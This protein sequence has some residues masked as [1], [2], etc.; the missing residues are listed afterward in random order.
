MVATLYRP[1]HEPTNVS[2]NG[3]HLPDSQT[4][5]VPHSNT[6]ADLLGCDSRLVDILD[7]GP[8][9]VAYSI[10]DCEGAVNTIA[11][12]ALSKISGHA[13][14]GDDDDQT[15]HGPILLLTT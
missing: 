10:F 12:E 13:Y 11:M 3:L 1:S 8:S 6:A 5:F 9:F 4:G 2:T 7:C 14:N 15:L